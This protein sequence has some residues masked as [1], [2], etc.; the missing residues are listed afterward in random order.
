M[1]SNAKQS[2]MSGG[3][4]M[5]AATL[6]AMAPS[7]ASAQAASAAGDV[8]AIVVT[9]SRIAS[10]FTTPTPVTVN[11]A[12]NL[13]QAA[14]GNLADGLADVPAF[15]GNTRTGNPATAAT[16]GANGQNLLNLRGLGAQRNLILL[17]GRRL[18]ATNSVGS[19]DVNM[20]PQSLVSRVDVVTGGASA[21]Y[22]SDAVAG[23]VNFVLD[24]GFEGL[25]GE[26]QGGWSTRA[27]LPSRGMSLAYGKG[28]ADGRGRAIFSAEY[29]AQNG[30]RADEFSDRDW[31]DFGYGRIPNPSGTT[32]RLVVVPDLRSAN[33]TY[34]G[35]ITA[36]PL[37][38]TTFEGGQATGI[39]N[40]APAATRGTAFA[41]G[42]DGARTNLGFSPDQDRHNLFGHVEYDLSDSLSFFVEG[43]YGKSHTN[44][45]NFVN[46]HTGAGNQ[47]TIFR[48]N[49]FLPTSIQQRMVA[50]NIASFPMGRYELD[51]PVVEIESFTDIKRATFGFDGKL[52]GAWTWDVYY[53]YGETNQELRENNVTINR[54]LYA[55]VD[56]VRDPATGN[57][58]C[59]STLLFRD[60]PGCVPLNL[61]GSGSPSAAAI[62]FVIGDSIK[63]LTLKQH[64]AAANISGDLGE[65]LQLGA[66]PIA[67]AAG[68]EYRKESADQT[69]DA[70]SQQVTQFANVR[71]FPASQQNR[72]GGYNFFNPLPLAG[73]Y[74]VKEAYGE[75]AL[76]VFRDL[77][78]AQ[79]LD[80][81]GAV[82]YADYSLSGGVTTWKAGFNYLVVDDL[83]LRLTRSR[84]IRGANILELFNSATQNSNNQIFRGVSYP[85][86]TISSGNPNLDPEKADTLTFG[87]VLRPSFIPGLQVSADYYKIELNGAI[88][89]IPNIVLRCEEGNAQACSLITI[90]PAN[91]MIIRQQVVNLSLIE[92]A[93]YDFELA[94]GREFMGGNL[95]FRVLGNHITLDATTAPGGRP[96]SALNTPGS[97]KWRATAQI[98]YARDNWNLFIQQRYIHKALASAQEVQGVD[99]ND[100]LVPA[101]TYTTIGGAYRFNVR[102]QEQ[103]LYFNVQNLFDMDPPVVAGNPTSFNPNPT[104]NAYDRVG[105]YFNVGLRFEW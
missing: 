45:G 32:P 15:A 37:A 80:L 6:L 51:M 19:F 26:I 52:G 61:F 41:G 50:G 93:G 14:P 79:S 1:S 5:V 9:G 47:F 4:L 12:E 49:P 54:N 53:T 55:A 72:P 95:S 2:L 38:N 7:L 33:G 20:L 75:V 94:Y 86:L 97:P 77:S 35:L 69:S 39:F 91:T 46:L 100:N 3:S 13:R 8:E 21:A 90:T 82:R 67:V 103:E 17:D 101:M 64:V 60:D 99:T 43:L 40:P 102:G 74:D 78:F 57:I 56:A 59:R 96:T 34:G 58:V 73:E 88:G 29:F 87:A 98:R 62:D 31:F 10:G 48:D 84:D 11:T 63:Y 42:G 71:G 76:P 28:F 30:I 70:V 44:S 92:T 27:D 18:P 83:R 66:G 81:N 23:V 16:G 25:K 89:N 22:G 85:N 104:S 65:K 105:R 36:G 24:T 68:V